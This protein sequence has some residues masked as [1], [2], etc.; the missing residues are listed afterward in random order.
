MNDFD[1]IDQLVEIQNALSRLTPEE[2]R[3][4]EVEG[5]WVE[6]QISAGR[7]PSP[8]KLLEKAPLSMRLVADLYPD[9]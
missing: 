3:T 9:Y 7:T 2:L 8:E 5:R 1:R 4:L 6:R